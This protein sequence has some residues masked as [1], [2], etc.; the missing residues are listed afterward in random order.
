[1]PQAM[2]G[3]D[4]L[5]RKIPIFEDFAGRFLEWV[6]TTSLEPKTKTY[7]RT[8]WRLLSIMPIARMKLNFIT[9]GRRFRAPL[10]CLCVKRQ[11]RSSDLET[12]AP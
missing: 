6:E 7:Y 10:P 5:P 2:E 4:P 9:G 8:G 1:M 11:L 3:N 12:H